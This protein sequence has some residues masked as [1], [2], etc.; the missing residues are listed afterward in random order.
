MRE[1]ARDGG[2]EGRKERGREG[3]QREEGGEAERGGREGGKGRKR[4]REG[5]RTEERIGGEKDAGTEGWRV[6]GKKIE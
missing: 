2:S 6:G 5:G 3:R 4:G 1:V